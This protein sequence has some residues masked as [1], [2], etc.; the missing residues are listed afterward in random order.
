MEGSQRSWKCWG[1]D[2]SVG[3]REVTES[4]ALHITGII[5]VERKNNIGWHLPQV[6]ITAD[7]FTGAISNGIFLHAHLRQIRIRAFDWYSWY[8]GAY[9]QNCISKQKCGLLKFQFRLAL[10]FPHIHLYCLG[11]GLGKGTYRLRY[12]SVIRKCLPPFCGAMLSMEVRTGR[13]PR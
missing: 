3:E 9:Y 11:R 5:H 4:Q 2:R 10:V 13:Q 12:K 1:I 7:I 6:V 8:G